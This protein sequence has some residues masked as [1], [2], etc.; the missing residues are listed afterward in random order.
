[1]SRTTK[2]FNNFIEYLP[3]RGCQGSVEY[4]PKKYQVSEYV[5]PYSDWLCVYPS[6]WDLWRQPIEDVEQGDTDEYTEEEACDQKPEP[7]GAEYNH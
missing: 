4:Q 2:T 3:E 5:K 1:M 7:Y 6:K